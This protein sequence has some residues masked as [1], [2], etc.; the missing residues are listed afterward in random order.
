VK[1]P[2]A[3]LTLLAV[4]PFGAVTG[5][6]SRP[7]APP[8]KWTG[9]IGEY[10]APDS[11]LYVLE[12]DGMLRLL[13]ANRFDG[14][15]TR[16]AS[17]SFRLDAGADSGAAVV[18]VRGVKRVGK[19]VIVGGTVYERRRIEP[20]AGAVFRIAP[21][22]PV[23]DLRREALAAVPPLDSMSRRQP[24]LVELVTLDNSILL[25]IRYATANNFMGTV[26]YSQPRAFLQR[27]AA[28]ALV[29]AHRTL[30][31]L[32]YG[33]LIHDGYRPWYVTKMFW[34]ATPSAQRDFVANPATGS[35]HNRGC[36]VDL[37][38]YSLATG[39]PIEMPG[40]YDEFSDRSHPDYPGGTSLQRWHRDLLRWAMER[41]GFTV[42]NVEWW[43]FDYA[44]WREYPVLN[45]TF[46][47][48]SP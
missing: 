36:A 5:Q 25:D 1:H 41:E 43:H 15:L 18:F 46:E 42:Y 32:G 40:T 27:P 11:M 35:R 39:L 3:L 33:L 16:L 28:E 8:A 9:L 45:L 26:F 47:E 31:R 21:Q 20:E 4:A 14:P 7:P 17:D 44:D 37:T 23:A 22:R 10:G 12:R 19:A 48:L 13:Q 38:L 24:D 29:R 6:G 30:K 2:L 34:D